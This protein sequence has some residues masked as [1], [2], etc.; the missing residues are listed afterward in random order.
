VRNRAGEGNADAHMKRQVTGREVVVSIT[1]GNPAF[2]L[3]E[4]IFYSE[5]DG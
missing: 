2:D 1:K 3:W 4:Q 5:F